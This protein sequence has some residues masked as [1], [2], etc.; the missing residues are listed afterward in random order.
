[1]GGGGARWGRE[2]SD[3]YLN[4]LRQCSQMKTKKSNPPL[5]DRNIAC[6]RI[7]KPPLLEKTVQRTKQNSSEELC[8]M[9]QMNENMN[10][11]ICE[12]KD[13]MTEQQE[14]YRIKDIEDKDNS[15]EQ[16]NKGDLARKK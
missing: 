13:K 11:E 14:G 7:I 12:L 16:I 10:S 9:N 4:M 15:I 6:K 5:K 3:K 2:N 1:M 8:I